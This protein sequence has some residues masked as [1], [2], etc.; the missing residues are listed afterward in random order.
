MLLAATAAS[1]AFTMA[2]CEPFM[3]TNPAPCLYDGGL[4]IGGDC[5]PDSGTKGDATEQDAGTDAGP[6]QV[7]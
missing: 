5:D 7:P 3:T 1:A 2:A 4:M 6:S